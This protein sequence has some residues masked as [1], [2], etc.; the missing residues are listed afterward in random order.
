MAG[1]VKVSVKLEVQEATGIVMEIAIVWP[2]V[3]VPL[4]GFI[5]TSPFPLEDEVQ[6]RL[7]CAL[8]LLSV[9]LQ[10]QILAANWHVRAT[11]IWGWLTFS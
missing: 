7:P 11:T 4:A 10:V 1:P 8:E 3:I 6:A 2:A 5:V 9:S